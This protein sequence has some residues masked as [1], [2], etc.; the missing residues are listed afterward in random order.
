MMEEIFLFLVTVLL[1]FKGLG[2]KSVDT[3]LSLTEKYFV[4]G[5][6]TT[7]MHGTRKNSIRLYHMLRCPAFFE[8]MAL[9]LN[10]HN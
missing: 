3:R 2:K 4:S 9:R 1:W 5:Y 10:Y 8:N 6:S 7:M